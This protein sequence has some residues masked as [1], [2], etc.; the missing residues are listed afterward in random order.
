MKITPFLFAASLWQ[1]AEPVALAQERDKDKENKEYKGQDKDN[2]D[3]DKQHQK[4]EYKDKKNK[5]Y[6]YDD[7]ESQDKKNKDY[8]D[9]EYQ[10][11][12]YKD[13]DERYEGQGRQRGRAAGILGRV[14]LPPAGTTAP[15]RLEGVPRGHYPPPGSC[16]IW[17]PNRPP[18]QQPAPTDCQR[19]ANV[20]LEPGAFILHGDRAYDASYDWREEERRRPGS[21]GRDILDILLPRR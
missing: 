6:R 12:D 18:G 2:R 14:I 15:R 1:L 11:K 7:Q 20:A 4:K 19:L 16:R 9:K 10:D 5:N 21:V 3:S 8:K 17:Y 13:R